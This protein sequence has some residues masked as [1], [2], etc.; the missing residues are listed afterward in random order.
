MGKYITRGLYE[1]VLERSVENYAGVL[2][3]DR[4]LVAIAPG[5]GHYAVSDKRIKDVSWQKYTR[6]VLVCGTRGDPS[7]TSERVECLLR[8]NDRLPDLFAFQGYAAHTPMQ[9]D[10]VATLSAE[11]PNLR[12]LI[13]STAEYHLPRFALTV[14]KSMIKAR[15]RGVLVLVLATKRPDVTIHSSTSQSVA[16]ELARIEQYQQSS[17]VATMAEA[18]EYFAF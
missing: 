12:H 6:S 15:C 4:T 14:I 10:W 16:E 5:G 17:H 1:H 7:Y 2:N 11:A 3:P 18:Y 9:A 8:R 13:L